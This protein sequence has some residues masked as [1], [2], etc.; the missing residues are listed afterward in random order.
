LLHIRFGAAYINAIARTFVLW[1]L[2]QDLR[3]HP[4]IL[5]LQQATAEYRQLLDFVISQGADL[6]RTISPI[7]WSDS[8]VNCQASRFQN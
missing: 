4:F 8:P 2:E 5:V 1:S 6:K 3:H 7:A